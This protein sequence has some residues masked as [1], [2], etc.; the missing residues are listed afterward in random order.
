MKKNDVPNQ[1]ELYRQERKERLAKNARKTA[2]KSPEAIKRVLVL[3]KVFAGVVAAVLC[4]AIAYGVLNFFS[5]PQKVLTA[6]NV[7]DRRVTVAEYNFYYSSAFMNVYQTAQQ[8]EQYGAG[9]GAMLTGF[10]YTKSPE[11]QT[12]K[13]EAGEEISY[14][15]KIH[16]TALENIAYETYY[17]NK[18]VEAGLSLTEEQEQEIDDQ[19]EQY[20]SAAKEQ[21]YSLGR[22]LNMYY[23]G[24]GEK[25]FKRLL[26]RQTLASSY[27]EK[28]KNDKSD[29]ITDEEVNAVYDEDP[30]AYNNVN[31]RL[32]GIA[33]ETAEDTE[34]TTSANTSDETTTQAADD[35]TKTPSAEELKA[36]EM[37]GRVTSEESFVA[38]C[39]E[40]AAED[41]KEAFENDEASLFLYRDFETVKSATDEETAKWVFDSARKAGEMTVATTAEYVYVIY[42]LE[43]AFKVDYAPV[44]VRHS[45]VQF[46]E[47]KDAD[48]N[49]V[50]LTDEKKAEYLAE[51][52]KLLADWKA[53]EATEDSFAKMANESS[54]D[55]ASTVG[56]SKE[57]ESDPKGGL[58][59]NVEKG[60]MVRAFEDWIFDSARQPGDTGIVE[61]TYGYHI[62]YF[63]STADEPQWRTDIRTSISDEYMTAQDEEA[64][65]DYDNTVKD[66]MFASW[67]KDKMLKQII[68]LYYSSTTSSKNVG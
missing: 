45:L 21:Q 27:L 62:M 66:G 29:A 17:Y 20:R 43:P 67:A 30:T 61:T 28:V 52:E 49:V 7:G 53:G 5:V 39:K 57:Y 22:F 25:T 23:K 24:V 31:L 9:Y 50:D 59:E 3:R 38:L 51:A 56:T 16:E 2:K 68:R 33:I 13:N 36:R 44:T 14:P 12:T 26:S 46:Q 41:D 15:Q 65:A 1:A 60:T 34:D 4:L 8:Y 37:M 32:F 64:K 35:E 63:V 47:E 19:I 6:A 58:Y 42:M 18:A 40:Y 48:G 10:D 55:L 11:K 54:D